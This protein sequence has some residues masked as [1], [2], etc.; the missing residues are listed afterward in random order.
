[1]IIN[2]KNQTFRSFTQSKPI[3]AE[4][5]KMQSKSKYLINSSSNY[6]LR[7]KTN[8]V[9]NNSSNHKSKISVID[10]ML[11]KL[12]LNCRNCK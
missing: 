10:S 11:S 6:N 12:R 8:Y 3:I 9:R 5:I 4:L 7:A 1:M 2:D